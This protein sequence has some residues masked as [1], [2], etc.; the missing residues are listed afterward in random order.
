MGAEVDVDTTEPEG[1]VSDCTPISKTAGDIE[2]EKRL[3]IDNG[4]WNVCIGTTLHT[5]SLVR[6]EGYL[7]MVNEQRAAFGLQPLSHNK[8]LMLNE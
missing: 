7:K 5:A 1:E 4:E 2:T 8:A 6:L 3:D